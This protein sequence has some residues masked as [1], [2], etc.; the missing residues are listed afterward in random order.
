MKHEAVFHP[1]PGG[2]LSLHEA[3]PRHPPLSSRVRFRKCWRTVVCVG[4]EPPF[5]PELGARFGVGRPC[6]RPLPSP[7]RRASGPVLSIAGSSR[8]AP[9]GPGPVHWH[10][11]VAHR[12]CLAQRVSRGWGVCPPSA[13]G[14]LLGWASGSAFPPC[15]ADRRPACMTYQGAGPENAQACQSHPLTARPK[16]CRGG[17]LHPYVPALRG[18]VRDLQGLRHLSVSRGQHLTFHALPGPLGT[19]GRWLGTKLGTKQ[20]RCR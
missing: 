6:A 12:Y 1:R 3:L 5:F 13:P 18:E 10:S 20:P 7:R 19:A 2:W 16:R 11:Q 15:S 4:V 8:P 9:L 17:Q 14:S